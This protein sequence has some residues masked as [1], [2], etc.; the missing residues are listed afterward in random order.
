MIENVPHDNSVDIWCLGVLCY[1]FCT[2]SPPF[3]S[4]NK[5]ETFKKIRQV[6]LNF[7][8]YLSNE[9]K[10]LI[11]RLLNRDPKKRISLEDVMIHPWIIKYKNFKTE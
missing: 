4:E 7:P 8:E 10:D 11:C 9:V 3:E 6:Q 1:E 2:G 5:R